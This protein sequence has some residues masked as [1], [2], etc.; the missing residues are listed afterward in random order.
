MRHFRRTSAAILLAI[1]LLFA[2]LGDARAQDFDGDSVDAECE[3]EPG[4]ACA[5]S[6]SKG[7]AP[8]SRPAVPVSARILTNLV[9]FLCADLPKTCSALRGPRVMPA[10]AGDSTTPGLMPKKS[11]MS[12]ATDGV[13]ELL[14]LIKDRNAEL[15]QCR[16]ELW[17]LG[18]RYAEMLSESNGI[19]CTLWGHLH[20]LSL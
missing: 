11:P 5:Q 2:V 18:N 12:Q 4:P 15:L 13:T 20:V 3:E 1:A 14:A 7:F 6:V 10:Q 16:E 9:G 19:E 17:T 8:G